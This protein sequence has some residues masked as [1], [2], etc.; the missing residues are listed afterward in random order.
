MDLKSINR[1]NPASV[2]EIIFLLQKGVYTLG[3]AKTHA[4][5]FGHSIKGASKELFIARLREA[6]AKAA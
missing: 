1:F 3:L 4:Y 6:A 5:Y 2:E